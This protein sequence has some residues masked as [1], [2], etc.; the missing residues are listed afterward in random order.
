MVGA[1]LMRE[2]RDEFILDELHGLGGIALPR[3]IE[4][5]GPLLVARWQV[6]QFLASGSPACFALYSAAWRAGFTVNGIKPV[7]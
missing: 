5:P 7:G 2:M 3:L 4:G 1:G 6:K